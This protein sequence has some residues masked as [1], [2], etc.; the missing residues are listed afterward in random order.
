MAAR[1]RPSGLHC[2]F[3]LLLTTLT[4]LSTATP[5]PEATNNTISSL[6]LRSTPGG[7][8]LLLRTLHRDLQPL[9]PT[10]RSPPLRRPHPRPRPPLQPPPVHHISNDQL[11]TRP[12]CNLHSLQDRSLVIRRATRSIHGQVVTTCQ[13]PGNV[14]L[15][16]GATD[17]RFRSYGCKG[18]YR[19]R[20]ERQD[21]DRKGNVGDNM[22]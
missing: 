17:G 13:G 2:Q 20:V 6:A 1:L 11:R 12:R 5:I 14:D 15:E 21:L 16:T 3:L 19:S 9:L 8:H 10:T 22:M 7:L 18:Q 4:I